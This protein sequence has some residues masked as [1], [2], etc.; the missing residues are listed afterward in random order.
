MLQKDER[1]VWLT[2]SGE[3]VEQYFNL[4]GATPPYCYWAGGT[5]TDAAMRRLAESNVLVVL[6]QRRLAAV[7]CR[8]PGVF[9]PQSEYRPTE[10]IQTWVRSWMDEAQRLQLAKALIAERITITSK[11]WAKTA[12]C[13]KKIELPASAIDTLR[14]RSDAVPGAPDRPCCWPKPNGARPVRPPIR[15][16]RPEI[17]P[18]GK[19]WGQKQQGR[20]GEFFGPR[21]P[22]RLRPGRPSP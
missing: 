14:Q 7:C 3:D 10:Y 11:A 2:D 1:I 4:P 15:R 8:R 21:Q 5:F 22:Y 6:R 18:S 17:H 9:H 19:A 12:R 20:A 13:C 16:L